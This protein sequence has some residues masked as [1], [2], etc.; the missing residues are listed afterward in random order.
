MC[1][2]ENP[3]DKTENN[4][5]ICGDI[6]WKRLSNRTAFFSS[7]PPS[8]LFVW[9]TL[10]ERLRCH[11]CSWSLKKRKEKEKKAEKRK[12]SSAVAVE[13]ED[14]PRKKKKKKEKN[15]LQ[16]KEKKQQAFWETQAF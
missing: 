4:T 9:L 6:C 14:Q 8:L 5:W 2:D 3:E 12:G 16:Q 1:A 10:K 11:T 7:S 15:L 13:E